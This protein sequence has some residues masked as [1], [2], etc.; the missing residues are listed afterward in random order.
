M[1]RYEV[2]FEELLERKL[3]FQAFQ[4]EVPLQ[5]RRKAGIGPMSQPSGDTM[6]VNSMS[7]P[8]T[9]KNADFDYDMIL[10]TGN[11]E[12]VFPKNHGGKKEAAGWELKINGSHTWEAL[13]QKT[14]IKVGIVGVYNRGKTTVANMLSGKDAKKGN[15]SHTTGL[16]AIVDEHGDFVFLDSAGQNQPIEIYDYIDKNPE[17]AQDGEADETPQ[18]MVLEKVDKISEITNTRLISD[19]FASDMVIALSDVLVVLVNQLTLEDQRYVRA[20]EKKAKLKSTVDKKKH[21][22]VVHNLKDTESEQD[23]D[24]LIKEDILEGFSCKER[25][26]GGNR[27]YWASPTNISH[28]ALAREATPAGDTINKQTIQIIREMMHFKVA[29]SLAPDSKTSL[30]QEINKY[31]EDNLYRYFN[32]VNKSDCKL[33]CDHTPEKFKLYA[34]EPKDKDKK[35]LKKDAMI[36]EWEIIWGAQYQLDYEVIQKLQKPDDKCRVT[37]NIDVPGVFSEGPGKAGQEV[38]IIKKFVH[39]YQWTETREGKKVTVL[40]VRVRLAK[41]EKKGPSVEVIANRKSSKLLVEEN[42]KG[43][44]KVMSVRDSGKSGVVMRKVEL[45]EFDD[46]CDAFEKAEVTMGVNGTLTVELEG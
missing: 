6:P 8:A 12:N 31:V 41:S 26:Y 25:D 33:Y 20:L 29:E 17:Q 46:M 40:E 11:L 18:N 44:G 1:A 34:K 38:P 39:D 14:K 32:G 2:P 30:L 15:L 5:S 16:S 10:D 7:K 42:L 27:R 9:E 28:L 3:D 4:K 36:S 37:V 43:R 22:I 45:G 13:R 24:T 21:I 35:V 23:L 19:V